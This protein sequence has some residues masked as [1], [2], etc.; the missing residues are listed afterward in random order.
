MEDYKDRRARYYDQAAPDY[1][2]AVLG[3]GSYADRVRPASLDEDLETLGGTISRL[4][5][6]GSS[7]WHAGLAS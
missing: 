6:V 7:T 3:I 4:H 1:D 2:S 5:Q